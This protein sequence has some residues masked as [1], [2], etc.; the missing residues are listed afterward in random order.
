MSFALFFVLFCKARARAFNHFHRFVYLDYCCSSCCHPACK[1]NR[2]FHCFQTMFVSLLPHGIPLFGRT[3][4]C[5]HF[6]TFGYDV[7]MLPHKTACNGNFPLRANGCARAFM[8]STFL[9][10]FFEYL[11]SKH[12]AFQPLLL[13]CIPFF[14]CMYVRV[15]V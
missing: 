4:N 1:G 11:L 15:C 3:N 12:A 13:L 2:H 7:Q 14:I 9:F 6:G 8:E 5:A 10:S